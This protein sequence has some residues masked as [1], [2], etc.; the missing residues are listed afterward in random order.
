MRKLLNLFICLFLHWI[1]HF[2]ICYSFVYLII[3]LF[4][5]YL[6]SLN[7]SLKRDEEIEDK[8]HYWI[9][10]PIEHRTTTKRE[11]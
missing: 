2:F 1:N 6:F 4:I 10:N 5:Y 9:K 8:R 11:Y 7:H 3:F